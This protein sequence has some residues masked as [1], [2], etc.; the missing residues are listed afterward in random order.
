MGERGGENRE[1]Y[2]MTEA[3]TFC[4]RVKRSLADANRSPPTV[5]L[6]DEY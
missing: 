3:H 2:V 1:H 6:T 4:R 5:R